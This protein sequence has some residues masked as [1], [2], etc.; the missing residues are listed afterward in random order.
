MVNKTCTSNFT[1]GADD[2]DGV[3]RDTED[4]TGPEK[5]ILLI[6]PL[7]DRIHCSEMDFKNIQ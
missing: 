5:T 1:D 7:W 4:L 6:F 3:I 2:V